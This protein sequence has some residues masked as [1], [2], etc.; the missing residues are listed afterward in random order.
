[1]DEFAV[2]EAESGKPADESPAGRARRSA[3]RPRLVDGSRRAA[4]E[5]EGVRL[6][7]GRLVDMTPLLGQIAPRSLDFH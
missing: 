3:P 7:A 5:G 4:G 6:I 2:R 1:M